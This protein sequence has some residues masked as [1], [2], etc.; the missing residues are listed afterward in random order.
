MFFETLVI[1]G[2]DSKVVEVIS[3]ET[4]VVILDVTMGFTGGDCPIL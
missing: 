4:P 1:L 2:V 3:V